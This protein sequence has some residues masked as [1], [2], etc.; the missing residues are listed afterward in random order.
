MPAIW[1][2]ADAILMHVSEEAVLEHGL[3]LQS[4][5]TLIAHEHAAS[6]PLLHATMEN[7]GD[8]ARVLPFGEFLGR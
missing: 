5:A 1:S 3:P 8:G 7:M 4:G 2:K 6:F